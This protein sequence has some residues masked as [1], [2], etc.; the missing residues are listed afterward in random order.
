L[1]HLGRC[2]RLRGPLDLSSTRHFKA[3][4]QLVRYR[5]SQRLVCRP[6]AVY[7]RV[8][9]A[10]LRPQ[11]DSSCK[12]T[13]IYHGTRSLSICL[14]LLLP[15][16]LNLESMLHLDP[17]VGILFD[18]VTPIWQHPPSTNLEHKFLSCWIRH[19]TR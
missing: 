1:G 4:H 10:H 12:H 5:C 3:S 2:H 9:P 17:S 13:V 15:S 14:A 18:Q 19:L 16:M 8:E 11:T 6:F 7:F